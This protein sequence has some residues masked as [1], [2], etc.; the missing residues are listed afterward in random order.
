MKRQTDNTTPGGWDLTEE[1]K[2]REVNLDTQSSDM[3]S[4]NQGI[5][6]SESSFQLLLVLHYTKGLKHRF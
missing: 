3:F 5:K 1:D 2:S 6:E 4:G